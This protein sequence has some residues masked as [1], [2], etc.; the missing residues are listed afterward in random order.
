MRFTDLMMAF[1]ALL[2]AICLA[3]IFQPSLWIVA[4]VIALVNWVQIARVRLHRDHVRWPSASSSP[5]SARSGAGHGAHPL[6]AHPAAPRA[7]HHR[8]GHARHLDHRAARGDALLSRHRRAAADAVLG[9]HHLR[10]PDLLPGGALAGLLPRRA[11]SW[12]WR[13]P[14][15]SSATRCA[16][17]STRPSGGATD[18]GL[19]R[20][21]PGPGRAHPARRL[22]RSPS[23][24]S[25]CCRPIRCARSPAARRRR[26]RSRTSAAQLGLDQPFVVQYWRYLAGLVQGDLGRSYLQRTRGLRADRRAPAGD[27]AADGRR[28][29]SAS[30]SSA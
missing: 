2:L 18:G 28:P 23:A 5:P 15:T 29:S 21:P 11:R 7:D 22:A 4:L 25:T 6:P 1:P 30:W 19:S 26:R 17:C 10:E 20:P 8:L 12:C 3:A 16:T 24:C 13:S 14:S 27:A 9:Q